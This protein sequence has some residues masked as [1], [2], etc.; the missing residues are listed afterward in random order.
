MVPE[1]FSHLGSF[2]KD[3]SRSGNLILS[4]TYTLG[5]RSAAGN[6]SKKT[7]PF[8]FLMQHWR[9]IFCDIVDFLLR[10]NITSAFFSTAETIEMQH[11]SCVL[12][13]HFQH[14]DDISGAGLSQLSKDI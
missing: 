9:Q 13:E 8:K 1:K 6:G 7:A 10:L 5:I 3:K 11:I 2:V 14:F 4:S 12:C